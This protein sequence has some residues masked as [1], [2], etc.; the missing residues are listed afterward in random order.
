MSNGRVLILNQSYEPVSI[1]SA[2]KAIILIFLTKAE[3]VAKRDGRVVRSIN[4]S[5]PFPSV[6]RLAR[7]IKVPFKKIELSRRNILKRDGFR[8]QYCGTKSHELTIDHIIP[9]SRGGSDSWDNLV[10][11]CKSCNNKKADRTPEESGLHLIKR[12]RR[13]HHILFITQ[14]MGKVDE[15]WKPFLFME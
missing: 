7:Y 1:C 3:I 9:K 2:K 13:P 14:Y 5:M 4:Y 8:C 10:S 11:A 6:I 15:N 12:P